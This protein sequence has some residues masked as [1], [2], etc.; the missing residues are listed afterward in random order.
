MLC[1]IL[2]GEELRRKIIKRESIEQI[3]NWASDLYFNSRGSLPKEINDIL[4]DIYIMDAGPEFVLTIDELNK[5]ADM[6]VAEGDSEELFK[7]IPEVKD[8]AVQLDEIWMMCPLCQCVWE[9][10]SQY[11]MLQCPGCK[12][13]LHNPKNL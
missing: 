12:R 1:C 10:Q 11:G 7:S 8:K 13:K 5:I 9:T 4:R 3:S 2:L 6:L